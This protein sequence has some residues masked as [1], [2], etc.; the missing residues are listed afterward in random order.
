SASSPST[1]TRS[2]QPA[3]C[4][5]VYAP[6][7]RP[8]RARNAAAR[9][10]AVDLP[11]V[12]T[13]WIARNARCGSPISASN[14]CIRPRP[15]SSG[16]GERDSNHSSGEGIELATVA[17][18]LL[19]LGLDHLAGRVRD[20]ALVGQHP[21]RAGDLAPQPRGLGLHVHAVR[22]GALR[23][24]H[25]VEDALLLLVE[26]RPHAG[27]PEDLGGGLDRLERL[28]RRL[29]AERLR[30]RRDDQARLTVRQVRPDLSVT[31]GSTGCSSASSRSRFA[32]AVACAS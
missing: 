13:T 3:T 30:P 10:V 6:A 19:A 32:S 25:G 28:A 2:L 29:R 12:P 16:H 17:L 4:G 5:E 7:L 14:A 11:F 18:E 27:P 31:C 15:N 23:L 26:L 9:R 22:L 1:C 20:E 24:D 8:S 21:L